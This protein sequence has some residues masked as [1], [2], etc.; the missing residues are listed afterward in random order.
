MGS[1]EQDGVLR[2]WLNRVA[3]SNHGLNYA[4]TFVYRC[5]SDV[6]TMRIVHAVTEDGEREQLDSLSGPSQH[7]RHD[8][9]I[10]TSV[11]PQR[12]LRFPNKRAARNPIDTLATIADENLDKLY[13]VTELGEDRIAGRPTQVVAISPVDR[14][15]YG[16][17]LWLDAET[18]LALRSDMLD[19]KGRLVEQILFTDIAFLA[20]DD[21]IARL[22]ARKAEP[23][24]NFGTHDT[25]ETVSVLPTQSAQG[26]GPWLVGGLPTGFELREHLRAA[27]EDDTTLSGEH[28][29]Y[30]DGLAS[31][32]VFI[33]DV[34][35]DETPFMGISRMGAV[36]AFGTVVNGHQVTVVG[37]VPEATVRMM[38]QSVTFHAQQ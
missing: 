7:I 17:R 32:S 4:G 36:N 13:R 19:E 20:P 6:V 18:S 31:V 37:D 16:F 1:A 35:D 8:G 5:A 33:E 21:A 38:G 29:V 12:A 23:S 15:R 25:I 27:Y 11:F 10:V 34:S 22:D 26:A 24:T 2:D 14:F 30:S 28:F 9:Q 3:R